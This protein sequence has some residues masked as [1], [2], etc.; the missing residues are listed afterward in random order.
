MK[1]NYLTASN[2]RITRK[3]LGL[4]A[5]Y[6][7]Y[8]LK[9]SKGAYSLIENGKTEITLS[10]LEAIAKI[11]EVNPISLLPS[12]GLKN[13]TSYLNEINELASLL[14]TINEKMTLNSAVNP[15]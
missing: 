9:L 2:I 7:A 1:I 6:V 5:E 10:R 13:F 12:E 15:I 11:L 3:Q 4:S 8:K 14:K